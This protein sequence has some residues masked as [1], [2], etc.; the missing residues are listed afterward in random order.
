M[1]NADSGEDRPEWELM[2]PGAGPGEPSHGFALVT[3]IPPPLG[4]FLDE[5]RR[6]LVPL[7]APR[8]HVTVLPPRPLLAPASQAWGH[9]YG[10]IHNF[11]VFEIQATQIEIFASTGVIY[12]ELGAG[13]RELERM[14]ETLN[15]G[16]VECVE[17][18]AYHPHITLAQDLAPSEVT[19]VHDLASRRWAEH[20]GNRSFPVETLTFVQNTTDNQWLD[21]AQLTLGTVSWVR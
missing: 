6:E 20:T 9:V 21:L 16:P 14:H 19:R 18:F 10:R 5:L 7:C 17:P 4:R 3:Y 1:H 11:P 2:Q 15:A 12:I 8:A 13:R